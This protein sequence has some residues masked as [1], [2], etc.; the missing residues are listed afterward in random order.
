MTI[1]LTQAIL[2]GLFCGIA[3]C[4]IPYTAG[5]FMYNTVI[6][7]AVIVGAVLGDMPHAMMIGASLQLIYLGV[8]AAGG[9]Q[10]TD[11]C[12]AAYVAI[13]VA[14]ASGLNTNASSSR[15]FR[16]SD[17][18]LALSGGRVLCTKSR[19]LRRKR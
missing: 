8:I 17:F 18:E 15:A 6:F 3:K 16:S 13:P 2:L 14:M 9:N 12:L 19:C 1:S 11:P 5:A 7:N 10:P 4:C